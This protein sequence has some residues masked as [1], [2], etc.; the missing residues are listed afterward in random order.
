LT[1]SGTRVRVTESKQ[2]RAAADTPLS[3]SFDTPLSSR[4]APFPSMK[5]GPLSISCKAGCA[6]AVAAAMGHA[7]P[8]AP[9]QSLL[10]PRSA[11]HRP[12]VPVTTTVWIVV[13]IEALV[14]LCARRKQAGRQAPGAPPSLPCGQPVPRAAALRAR[15][16]NAKKERIKRKLSAVHALLVRLGPPAATRPAV[17]H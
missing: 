5:S 17:R 4:L 9:P 8:Q 14:A 10:P 3:L 11:C 12:R 7:T 2:R 13:C 6:T 16:P 15:V 1:L